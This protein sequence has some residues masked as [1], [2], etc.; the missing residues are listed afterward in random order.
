MTARKLDTSTGAGG[1][2]AVARVRF[3]RHIDSCTTCEQTLCNL[4]H[5]LWRKVALAAVRDT[6]AGA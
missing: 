2:V 6:K 5:A 3:D 1:T 4:A